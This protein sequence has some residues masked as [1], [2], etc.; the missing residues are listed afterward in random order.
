MKLN[1]K[2]LVF[3]LSLVMLIGILTVA[4][5]AADGDAGVLTIKY[6][7]GTVQTYAEGETITP[8][9]VPKDFI[10]YDA[11]GKAY[12][13]TVTGDAWED[14]P[15]VATPELIGT[16]V[17]A[18]VAGTQDSRQVFYVTEEQLA[19]DA[20]ITKVYHMN[21]NVH[22]YL[23]S[24]NTGD[25]GDGT[26]TGAAPFT[27]LGLK[28]TN[29]I[30]I[31]LYADVEVSSFA[32]NLMQSARQ[33]KQIPTY[34]D[35]NGHTVKT[36]QTGYI[37]GKSMKM[38]I[39]SSVPGAHWYQTAAA[40]M[41][42]SN[43]DFRTILG[44][45][46][47]ALDGDEGNISF[48]CKSLFGEMY[49]YGYN[50]WGGKYYQTAI[51]TVGF[52]DLSR[53]STDI[54]NAEFYTLPGASPL[55]DLSAH[56]QDPAVALGKA[57]ILNC[58]FYCESRVDLLNATQAA[59]I[60][61]E[62]CT[63]VNINLAAT[64]GTGKVTLK[65]GCVSNTASASTYGSG[66]TAQILARV[67]A[68][69]LSGLVDAD[70]NPIS[71]N[72][73]YV[74]A[75]PAETLKITTNSGTEYW[76]VGA[77]FPT[78]AGEFVQVSGNKLLR[79]PVYDI[80]GVAEIVD[81]KVAAAG[82]I[83]VS[84]KFL[85]EDIAAF[86]YLDTKAGKL[87]GVGYVTDCGST[88]AGVGDKFHE[89]FADPASAYVITMYQDMTLSKAVPFGPL[90][91]TSDSTHNRDYFDS[92]INGSIVWDLNGTTV[93]VG[94]TVTGLVR[95]AAANCGLTSSVT[96]ATYNGN[97]VF[98]FEGSSTTNTF[99]LKSSVPGGKI[100]NESSAHL[101]GVGEGKKTKI[102]FEGENLTI[103]SPKGLILNSG[104]VSRDYKPEDVLFGV[105]GG[106]YICGSSTAVFNISRGA[107][108]KNA[109]V[110]TTSASVGQ[111]IRLDGYRTGALT[112]ENVIFS[113]ANAAAIAFKPVGS[114]NK[115]SA[116]VTDCVFINCVP[117][118]TATS[119][120]LSS[121]TY[122]GTN[123]ADTEANLALIYAS[124]PAG[125]A[126]CT[127]NVAVASANGGVEE[128]VLFGYAAA[129]SVFTVTYG[130]TGIT[131]YYLVG[132]N[133]APIAM[134]PAYYTVIFDLAAG[135]ANIP[136]AWTGVPVM[137]ILDA[138]Y[139]GQTI[140]A[141]PADNLLPIAFALTEGE[142][143]VAYA[144]ADSTV[145]GADL[146]SAL[147]AQANAGVLYVY[148][149][150]TAPA[151]TVAKNVTVDLTGKTLTL[152]GVLN[153]DADLA[154]TGGEILSAEAKPF[155]VSGT[156]TLNATKLYLSSA[157][158]VFDGNG[159]IALNG[160]DI[161]NLASAVMAADA[162]TV[163]IN[164]AKLSGIALGANVTVDG[165]V[166]G[167]AGTFA[168]NVYAEGVF[169]DLTVNNNT[170]TVTVLG[171][172]YNIVYAVAATNDAAKA[173]TITYVYNN[174]VRGE[175]KYYFGSIASFY[176]E[177]TSGYYFAYEGENTL[178]ES[179]TVEC[180][181]HADESKLKTQLV[182][183]D[184][185]NFTYYLQVE[186][187]GVLANLSLNG[188]A[189]DFASLE[190]REID[191]AMYYVIP[192]SFDTFADS[193]A[194]Y[195]LSVDLVGEDNSLTITANAA[196]DEYLAKILASGAEEDAKK[197]Y[198]VANYVSALMN[199]FD[200]DFI[201]GDVRMKNLG[202]LNNLLADYAEYKVDAELPAETDIHSNYVKSVLLVA[203]EKLT[204]AFR[205]P[206]DFDGSVEIGGQQVNVS[207]AF[208]GYERLYAMTTVSFA[209]LDE[210]IVLTVKDAD[211]A[212][213]ETMTY[214][215]ADYIAGVCVQNE[216]EV[217]AYAK[218]IWNLSA[219]IG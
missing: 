174:V 210:D 206:N 61:L 200:Y 178:A 142:D 66:D 62:N 77:T 83:S 3:A 202:R 67:D 85:S 211:G 103:V 35:L 160:V 84:I 49:G 138:T 145:I 144:L 80:D 105:D 123:L 32:M 21:N 181:F 131:K 127:F 91:M 63:F 88:A 104:E 110:I 74:T 71:A 36:T 112:L 78:D 55:T 179:A 163:S 125:T 79:N 212:V 102:V 8:P 152:G 214:S 72:V 130:D 148:V 122:N 23:S 189:I 117:S 93:T 180:S 209:D 158:V 6:Q 199:Y 15:S 22:Q 207:E 154:V 56:N 59:K 10:V 193:L 18:T 164:G 156:L 173:I 54:R 216:G 89:L 96:A 13:Y 40:S 115:Y 129:S 143:V 45:A 28:A 197:A 25:K 57:V 133:F 134:D 11:D 76:A 201:Y 215:L 86:T 213:V 30:R 121:V 64:Q 166:L 24:A 33:E 68:Y 161:H 41:F 135:T 185:L 46:T 198:A 34:F 118:T 162:A 16:T 114:S 1:K 187:A 168:S 203:D 208:E 99:T 195:V 97:T 175:Q 37:D 167:T 194:D 109:T 124:A 38:H 31:K 116:T 90:V 177:F 205:V 7:D 39:Y 113:S 48:H 47:E 141:V 190:Q 165:T 29:L 4:A 182:L 51:G 218:A 169:S 94:P 9:A 58:K 155:A 60:V 14:V 19:A 150:I 20:P 119:T 107:S 151:L 172:S 70:G 75:A 43:D 17:N 191:G 128:K 146:A 192:V 136:V 65:S 186:D 171:E 100:V 219:V 52:V 140:T 139:G 44:S 95:M 92:L 137:G 170:E 157:T 50:I 106:T 26:N 108:I 69:A 217:A 149:D 184:A 82:E 126:K 73:S 87:Y 196:M 111:L 176:S 101:F 42:R 188:A 120:Q 159:V 204:F 183:T 53:R 2:L 153:V 81:G 98:G 12:K 27:T 132:K 5:F 147:A